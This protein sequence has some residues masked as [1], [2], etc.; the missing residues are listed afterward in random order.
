MGITTASNSANHIG[1]PCLAHT[2]LNTPIHASIRKSATATPSKAQGQHAGE[3]AAAEV[4]IEADD[5]HGVD[6]VALVMA[7]YA[8]FAYCFI[9]SIPSSLW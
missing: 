3:A 5:G 2:K 6:P 1:M 8:F 9:D 7:S 4:A